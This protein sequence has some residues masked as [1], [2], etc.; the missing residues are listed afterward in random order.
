MLTLA[1]AVVVIAGAVS[2]G[3]VLSR[4]LPAEA[5][6]IAL[7]SRPGLAASGQAVVRQTVSGWSIQLTVAHLADLGPGQFL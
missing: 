3:L 4:P 7:S 2:A 1:A 5:Y 6:T